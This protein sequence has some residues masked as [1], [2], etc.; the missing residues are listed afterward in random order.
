MVAGGDLASFLEATSKKKQDGES[1]TKAEQ[2]TG[3]QRPSSSRGPYILAVLNSEKLP[4]S[5][6]P[7]LDIVAVHDA[8][9]TNEDAW[10]FTPNAR[11]QKGEQVPAAETAIPRSLQAIH[12]N[13]LQLDEESRNSPRKSR[14]WLTDPT[15]L[16]GD[17]DGARI[18]SF[19]YRPPEPMMQPSDPTPNTTFDEYLHKTA[20]ALLSQ[21]VSQRFAQHRL[22]Y[23][24]V[25][26][27]FIGCG[28]GCLLIQKL[29][30][31]AD[32]QTLT[33]EKNPVASSILQMWT[34]IML[35]D[36]PIPLAAQNEYARES[37]FPLTFDDSN[38]GWA[39]AFL[40]TPTINTRDLWEK[41]TDTATERSISVCWFYGRESPGQVCSGGL[42]FSDACPIFA[43][44]GVRI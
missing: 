4:T 34:G 16:A 28:F 32:G 5:E 11:F 31:L 1:D 43:D 13:K 37:I 9:Q 6:P 30:T 35:L 26:L 24:R 23:S 44:Q 25:P 19:S 42:G 17:F 8:G 2:S 12:P 39:G 29:I 36:M 27:V 10:T 41:F 38:S 7:R 14:N 40:K 18:M 20:S 33:Q 21:L 3:S 15:M 22:D